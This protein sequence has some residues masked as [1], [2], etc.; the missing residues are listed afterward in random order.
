MGVGVCAPQH[1]VR[2][3]VV[4]SMR[5][6]S[7]VAV[8]I[9]SGSHGDSMDRVLLRMLELLA[10]CSIAMQVTLLLGAVHADGRAAHSS[11]GDGAVHRSMVT[12][13]IVRVY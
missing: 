6:Y 12:S 4:T 8:C 3:V 1:G 2:Y 11:A 10:S 13:T 5:A 7:T 9:P